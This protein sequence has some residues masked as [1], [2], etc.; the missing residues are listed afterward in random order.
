MPFL[1]SNF[2]L[3]SQAFHDGGFLP[4]K[5]TF[6][7]ENISPPLTI[8]NMPY[9]TR[10]MVLMMHAPNTSSGDWLHWSLYNI[11]R[12]VTEIAEN[13]VPAGALQGSISTG[14][15][16]YSGP[17]PQ[18]G[19]GVRRYIFELYALTIVLELESGADRMILEQHLRGG[20]IIAQTQLTALYIAPLDS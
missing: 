11:P 10:S 4:I 14:R 8:A 19:T 17:N 5:Y 1:S 3:T 13:T 9:G 7:G 12:E 6:R 2:Q 18:P 15:V 20:N 16:G